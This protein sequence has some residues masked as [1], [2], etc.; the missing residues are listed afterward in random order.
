VKQRAGRRTDPDRGKTARPASHESS[1][2]PALWRLLLAGLLVLAFYGVL[3]IGVEEPWGYDEYYHLGVARELRHQFPLRAFPWTPFSILVERYADKEPLFHILLM[4]LAGLPVNTAALIGSLLGQAFLIGSVA[5]FLR[6]QRVPGGAGWLLGLAGLGPFFILRVEQLRPHVWM[7]GFCV[8]VLGLLLRRARPWV[9]AVVCA[10]FGL[11]HTAGW[12]AVPFALIWSLAGRFAPVQPPGE[13]REERRFEIAPVLAAA[14]GWLAG[15]LVHPNLPN[16]FWLVWT[17]NVVVPLATT[18]AA[19]NQSLREAIGIDLQRPPASF[20][21]EQWPLFIAPVLAAVRL[22]RRPAARTRPALTMV[23]VT[24]A[25]LLVGAF[26][27]RRLLEIGAVL[28][29]VTLALVVAE[30]IRRGERPPLLSGRGR[31]AAALTLALAVAWTVW[32]VRDFGRGDLRPLGGGRP[33][34]MA[35]FL[36]ENGQPGSL[37]FTAQ[38]A[39]SA[40][41]FYAAPQLKSLV[42][43][44]PT[45][46]YAKDPQRFDRYWA[47]AHGRSGDPVGEIGRR[48]RARYITIWKAPGFQPLALAL[49]RDR[50]AWMIYE[51]RFYEIWEINV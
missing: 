7:L 21:L 3:R 29:I 4:P 32:Q 17:Q 33:L 24:A 41:L 11:M 14:G 25:F 40:P 10:L 18:A 26:F 27:L 16:N 20:V 34:A 45:F 46:F 15:Q 47:L 36:G 44:D 8:L 50:R 5:W 12:V 6:S 37:V 31:T 1:R 39:D 28:G 35:R 48:F 43:L 42:V 49:R 51:D 19:A 9:L 13:N 23:A 22:V 38:W 30:E 2:E